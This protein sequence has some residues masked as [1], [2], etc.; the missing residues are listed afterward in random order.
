MTSEA[1]TADLWR[2]LRFNLFRNGEERCA[3]SVY[4]VP[5][6][7]EPTCPRTWWWTGGLKPEK[8]QCDHRMERLGSYEL[9]D[10]R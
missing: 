10:E 3:G 7:P 1:Y 2:C 4:V 8:R 5:G 9:R 6:D